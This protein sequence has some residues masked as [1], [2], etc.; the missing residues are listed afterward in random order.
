LPTKDCNQTRLG[1]D[2]EMVGRDKREG[3]IKQIGFGDVL[4]WK[5]GRRFPRNV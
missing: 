2:E 1:R 5:E 3:E 4:F